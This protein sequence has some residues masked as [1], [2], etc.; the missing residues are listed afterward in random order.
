MEVGAARAQAVIGGDI[1]EETMLRLAA[2]YGHRKDESEEG[3][4]SWPHGGLGASSFS[5]A[6]R[7]LGDNGT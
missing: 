7:T 4:Q 1:A 2:T 3:D 5:G 6:G